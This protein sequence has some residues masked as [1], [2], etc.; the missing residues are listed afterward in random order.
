MKISEK[1][2]NRDPVNIRYGASSCLLGWVLA[3]ASERGLRAVMLGDDLA[4]LEAEL[5]SRFPQARPAENDPDFAGWLAQVAAC[6]D[7]PWLAPDVPLDLQGTPFQLRVWLALRNIPPG[8]TA[9]YTEIAAQIGEAPASSMHLARAV[10]QACA[11]NPLAV[12]VPC[13]RMQRRGGHLAGYRWGLERKRR[14]LEMEAEYEKTA[15]SH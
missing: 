14:L 2:A 1:P 4:L 5:L 9:T 7:Q 12:V 11:A 15:G 13:H 6:V 3:A 10:G 8:Q